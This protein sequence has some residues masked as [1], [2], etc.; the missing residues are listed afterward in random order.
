MHLRMSPTGPVGS[1]SYLRTKRKL[2]EVRARAVR[3]WRAPWG[4][5]TPLWLQQTLFDCDQAILAEEEEGEG[6]D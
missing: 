5:T 3:Q 4:E 6:T 2:S 1:P